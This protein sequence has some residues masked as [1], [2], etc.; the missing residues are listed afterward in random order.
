MRDMTAPLDTCRGQENQ[1]ST[2]LS[3]KTGTFLAINLEKKQ[4][5]LLCRTLCIYINIYI[6]IY[7]IPMFFVPE[8]KVMA[9]GGRFVNF[10]FVD[11]SSGF[12]KLSTKI[13]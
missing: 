11:K 8:D 3:N 10:V 7:V 6:Y 5:D 9:V 13:T 12:S 1:R 2:N 4:N